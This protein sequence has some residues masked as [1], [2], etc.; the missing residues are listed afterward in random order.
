M[1]KLYING[2]FNFPNMKDWNDNLTSEFLTSI[3]N[4]QNSDKHIGSEK[5]QI[6]LLC[7]VIYEWFLTQKVSENTRLDNLL[8]LFF[9]N[10]DHSIIETEILN[11]V[12]L[13]DHNF[14]IV[15]TNLLFLDVSDKD[16]DYPYS[17]EIPKYDLLEATDKDW[18]LLNDHFGSIDWDDLFIGNNLD[19]ITDTLINTIEN[20]VI[21]VLKEKSSDKKSLKSD[22]SKYKSRNLIPREVCGLFKAKCKA[23]K[24]MKTVKSVKRCLA[25]RRRIGDID[26]QLRKSY[27]E[28]KN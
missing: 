21:H 13:S 17:T 18:T 14:I 8:D 7:D 19:D 27:Q 5:S 15:R 12:H 10:D 1:P 6:K 16:L 4:R 11:N 2:D 9:T 22:G 20:G 23:S 25:L 24:A 3:I 28:R 26:N